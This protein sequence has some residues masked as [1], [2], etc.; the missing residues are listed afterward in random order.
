MPKCKDCQYRKSNDAEREME[1]GVSW[2]C[3]MKHS[4]CEDVVCLLRMIIW[5]IANMEGG[6]DA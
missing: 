3:T 6:E 4:E 5:E 2:Y 1:D